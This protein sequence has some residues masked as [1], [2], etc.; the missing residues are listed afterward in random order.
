MIIRRETANDYNPIRNVH[1]AAFA[2]HPFTA[3]SAS[4]K[5]LL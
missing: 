2:S 4:G 5:T 1:I 3:A